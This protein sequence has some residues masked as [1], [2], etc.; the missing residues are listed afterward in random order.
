MLMLPKLNPVR[1]RKW[2]DFLRTQPCIITGQTGNDYESVIGAHIG[3]L[4]KG[5]KRGDDEV[6]PILNRFHQAGHGHG[7][8]SMFREQIPDDVLRDA[9]RAFAREMYRSWKR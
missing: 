2:L 8:V 6:L 1:D 5:I 4:G 3:T 7:E 9:L